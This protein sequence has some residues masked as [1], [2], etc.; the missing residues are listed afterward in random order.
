MDNSPPTQLIADSISESFPEK[1]NDLPEDEYVR[2]LTKRQQHLAAIRARHHRLWICIIGL[3]LSAIIVAYATILPH[4]ISRLWILLPAALGLSGLQSLAKN[5]RTHGRVQRIVNFYDLGLA[6]LRHQW[7]ERGVSG[8]EFRPNVHPY[9]SDLDLF[10]AGSVFEMLC[11]ARTGVGRSTLANW[12]LKAANCN[13]VIDRQIAVAELRDKLD[14]REHWASAGE[15]ALDQVGLSTLGDWAD[16][17]AVVV[18]IYMQACAIALPFCLIFL[19]VLSHFGVFGLHW[20]WTVTVPTALEVGL[21]VTFLK[22]TRTIAAN[23][24]L[25]SFEL[26]LIVP[27]LARIENE[28]FNSPLLRSLQLRL[29]ASAH[30]PSEQIRRL[31]VLAWLLDLRRFEYFTLLASPLLWG[32]NLAILTERWRQCNREALATWLESLGQFEA[33]LSLA[34]YAYENPD[35]TFPTLKPQSP[36]LF[37]AEALGHPLLDPKTCVRCDLSLDAHATQLMMVSGSNM[38][39]KS[40]LLRSV[41]VNAVLAFAGAPVRANRLLISP[42]QIGCSIAVQD[43]LLHAKSRFQAEIERLKWVLASAHSSNT[44]FLLDEVLG[45]TNSNDRLLGVNAILE[46]FSGSG[47]I[48][49]VTTHDLAL[50]ESVDILNG[51]AINVHFEEHYQDGEMRFDYKMKPGTLT[52]T[53]GMN[54]MAAL[55]LLPSL[56]SSGTAT[57]VRQLKT[58]ANI[59]KPNSTSPPG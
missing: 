45:G 37:Q 56:E 58:A 33:L 20:Y 41:G 1:R 39:G 48:G 31:S 43:S 50:T 25:P 28:T 38:S 12:L 2:R 54:V 46:Q 26:A 52:R 40:T 22:K 14:L 53:N 35:H 10:G 13:E 59:A 23:L 8:K 21:A 11:T 27:L 5:A 30:R 24:T 4:S 49:M 15:D 16:E 19:S 42:L 44:L 29:T 9:A 3:A 55:G 51:H 17:P 7:Q 57:I 6:R 18:P 47:A 34:Q 36:P 32:T